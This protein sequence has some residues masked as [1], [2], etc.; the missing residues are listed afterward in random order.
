[1]N[2]TVNIIGTGN[3]GKTIGRLIVTNRLAKIQGVFNRTPRHSTQGLQFIG[4]GTLYTDIISLP[5]SDIVLIATPDDAVSEV[6]LNLLQNKNIKPGC[7]IIHCSGSLKSDVLLPLKQIGCYIASIHPMHSFANPEISIEQY[8]GTFCAVEG[9]KEAT[10]VVAELFNSIGSET[11]FINKD[12]KLLYH[13]AGVFASN[14]LVTLSQQSLLCLQGAGVE[15]EM[16]MKIII[17]IMKGTVSNLEKTMSPK[18][19]LTGPIQ[20]GD[21]V[22]VENHLNALD[23]P[24]QKEL[25]AI[26]GQATLS[27]TNL[28]QEKL[29]E[30]NKSLGC[31][32]NY[33]P[34][35]RS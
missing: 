33:T 25:Y 9:D 27:L 24:K 26:L 19:S 10:D 3:L 30:L 16:A 21:N 13:A 11:Y 6:C 12:K 23:S 34:V 15:Q 28:N 17:N 2:I 1:M 4:E 20:R 7:I 31:V 18:S 5:K 35:Q 32:D 22:T 8:A 14:Y 29:E